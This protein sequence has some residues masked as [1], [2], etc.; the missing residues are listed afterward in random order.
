MRGASGLWSNTR[1]WRTS[2]Q[3]S[4]LQHDDVATRA[5]EHSAIRD[6]MLTGS[7]DIHLR[8]IVT[9]YRLVR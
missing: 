1:R 2:R 8:N 5:A 7:H 6:Q 3:I 9:K 4:A